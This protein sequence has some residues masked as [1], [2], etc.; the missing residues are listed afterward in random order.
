M[1]I[2]A[3]EKIIIVLKILACIFG[4]V[5]IITGFVKGLLG[6]SVDGIR[7]D[8]FTRL[9][10]IYMFILG[11]LYCM[12]NAII[13]KYAAISAIYFI[14]TVFPCLHLLY[15]YLTSNINGLTV[16]YIYMLT[17]NTP[18]ELTM[19]Y[20]IHTLLYLTAPLSLLLSILNKQKYSNSLE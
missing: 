4:A 8:K 19:S 5:L 3:N 11:A 2:T 16:Y 17:E 1:N 10:S 6:T 14:V 20:I 18:K 7:E 13:K 12:P 15:A 9:I